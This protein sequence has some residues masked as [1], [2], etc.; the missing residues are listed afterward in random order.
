[1]MMARNE[2][3]IYLDY[4]ATT[5]VAPEVVAAMAPFWTERFYN[6][7]AT[8]PEAASVKAAIADARKALAS[9]LAADPQGI[10]FTSGG[11]E[12]NN[13]VLY[14]VWRA[15]HAERRRIVVSAI[16]HPSV[17]ATAAGLQSLGAEIVT[18]PVDA[19]GVTR[20]DALE[21]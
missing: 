1:M 8:Y 21:A 11:T 3:P 2:R 7:S 13:W 4:N 17:L 16:E 14:G 18:L 20:L 15:R 19:Q 6:P 10:V 12:A 5:P 9:L